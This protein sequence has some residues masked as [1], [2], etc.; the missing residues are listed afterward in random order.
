MIKQINSVLVLFLI[1][2]S[3]VAQN[4]TISG[5]VSDSNSGEV[6]PGAKISIEGMSKGAM[7]DLD[8][9]FTIQQLP[10]G[11]YSLN[12]SYYQYNS[13]IITDVIV[14]K[15]E[16]SNVNVSIDKVVKEIGPITVKVTINKESNANLLQLQKNAAT[17]LDGISSETIKKSPDRAASDVLKRISGA[18]V[19]DN[20]FVVIRGLN[21]RYNTAM[22]N[23]LPLPSTE[24][25]RKA[26][27]FDIFPSNML[28]NMLIYKTASPDLPGDFA[29]GVILIN[30]K[31][32]PEKDYFSFTLGTGL[33][34]QST[35]KEF[36]NYKGSKND[37]LGAGIAD[38]NTSTWA[39]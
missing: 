38:A 26:F 8:G 24:P 31:D 11:K 23:G 25:D 13:K 36:V 14:K 32:I 5:K 10:E 34:T 6:I 33:N 2:L 3:A 9:L 19:Q 29:G 30:T 7:T 1:S 15:D 21:D 16:V 35:F 28:D 37:W 39:K 17:T 20:K 27:S 12:V 22:I 4:G 18:S